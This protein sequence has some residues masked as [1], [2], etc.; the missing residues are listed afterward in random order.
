MNSFVDLERTL[1]DQPARLGVVLSR[2]DVGRGREELYRDQLPE[3]LTSLAEHARIMSITASNAIEGVVVG[4]GRAERLVASPDI[5]FRNRN[6]KEFA[7]YRDAIDQLMRADD[8]ERVSIP[9]ILHL[10]RQILSHVDGRGGYLKTEDNQII[11]RDELGGKEVIFEPASHADTEFFLSELVERYRQA[12]DDRVAHPL[13]LVGLLILDFLAIHPVA[14]GNGRVARLL[15][16]HEL[17]AQGYSVARYVSVEQRV[18]ETKNAYYAALHESQ[19]GWHDRQHDPWP[20]I[21]YLVTVL[22]ECYE[23]F[24]ERVAQARRQSGS[25]KQDR[26]RLHVLEHGSADF[27]IG[28]IRRALPG[29]SDPTIRLVLGQLREEGRVQVDGTGRSARWRRT[30]T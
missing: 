25:S 6:E 19:Q 7:G 30:G 27:S 4:P 26:V 16:T 10:H 28:D 5:R 22:S 11:R 23:I 3:L 14:D 13:V 12:Q 17:L 18:F 2:V 1:A 21:R 9:L 20:W 24:E 29:I 15:T 8:S